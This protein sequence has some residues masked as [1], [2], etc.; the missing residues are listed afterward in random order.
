MRALI[1]LRKWRSVVQGNGFSSTLC[2]LMLFLDATTCHRGVYRR[3]A[4]G[5]RAPPE[6]GGSEKGRSLISA[7]RSLAVTAST[8]GFEKLFTALLDQSTYKL[9]WNGEFRSHIC[10]TNVFLEEV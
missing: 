10:I 5:A 1:S 6:F 7:Y 9:H 3:G 4:G 2:L 8:S